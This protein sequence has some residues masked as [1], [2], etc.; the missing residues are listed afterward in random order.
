[1]PSTCLHSGWR[2]SGNSQHAGRDHAGDCSL[3]PSTVQPRCSL[4]VPHLGTCHRTTAYLLQ[5]LAVPPHSVAP[6]RGYNQRPL[7]AERWPCRSGRSAR[8]TE[9][10]HVPAQRTPAKREAVLPSCLF[11]SGTRAR[12][13]A[14]PCPAPVAARCGACGDGR[15]GGSLRNGDTNPGCKY[16]VRGYSPSMYFFLKVTCP[17]FLFPSIFGGE[18]VVVRTGQR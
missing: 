14:G 13:L 4:L 9:P 2:T 11:L 10:S 15:G 16:L 5:D 3:Q 7:P 1:M 17:I 6:G 12:W 8:T 18:V